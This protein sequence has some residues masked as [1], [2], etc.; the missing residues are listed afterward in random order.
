[1]YVSL[2]QTHLPKLDDLG[3]VTYDTDA[4]EV[5]LRDR[6]TEITTYM[7]VV[8]RYGITWAEYYLV[9]G[10]LGFGTVLAASVGTP[11]LGAVGAPAV[12]VVYLLLLA[13]SA[14]F[15]VNSQDRQLFEG[16]RSRS[17]PP[18]PGE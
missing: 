4:K 18:K 5:L 10:V 6:A 8:P 7:E 1:V 13:G 16:L 11:L 12:A 17:G 9:L 15:H 14:A 2:H 3:I